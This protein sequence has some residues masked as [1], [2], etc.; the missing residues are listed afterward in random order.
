MKNHQQDPSWVVVAQCNSLP[1]AAII[2]GAIENAGIPT[3]ILNS[4]LQSALPLTYTWAPVEVSV[5]VDMASE[6]REIV[7][8]ENRV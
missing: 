8:E 5:P 2:A 1:D 3:A 7:P 6:A 4:T